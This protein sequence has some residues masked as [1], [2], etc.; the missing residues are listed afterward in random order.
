MK[1]PIKF[2]FFMAVPIEA[3]N[4]YFRGYPVSGK[5]LF[6]GISLDN[7]LGYQFNILH[8][9]GSYASDR[10]TLMGYPQVGYLAMV[11]SGY[12]GTVLLLIALIFFFGWL[13]SPSVRHRAQPD[14][15]A[16][17]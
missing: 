12:L 8:W 13:R 15:P 3:A 2:A 4:M 11:A 16:E 14:G 9:P 5:V 6:G 7:L 1:S 10:L 17:D